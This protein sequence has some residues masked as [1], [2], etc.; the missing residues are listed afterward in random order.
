M[1]L[2]VI[3]HGNLSAES[4]S[5]AQQ[6]VKSEISAQA[7]S[8]GHEQE[9]EEFSKE[10]VSLIK[11]F[12]PEEQVL[13]LTDL[14]G[15]TP[16]NL[17]IPLLEEGRVELLTGLNLSILLYVLSQPLSKDFKKLCEG[18]KKA[19]VESVVLAGEFL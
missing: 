14:F 15:G 8:F 7:L 18:A 5:L 17:S 11:A 16:S 1:K 4:L 2:I 3:S 19:G 6:M 10:L 13:I 9:P 12:G